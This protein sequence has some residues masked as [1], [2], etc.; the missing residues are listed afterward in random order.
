MLIRDYSKS[1]IA[2]VCDLMKNSLDYDVAPD[3]LSS[4]IGQMQS[5][6]EYKILIAEDN[7]SVLGFIGL[8]LG[9]AFEI[10]GKVMRVIALAVR[11]DCQGKGIGTMLVAESEKYAKENG[12]TVIGVNSGLKRELAHKFYEKQGFSRKGYSF[13]KQVYWIAD[14]E[15]IE[16]EERKCIIVSEV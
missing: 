5:H 13:T 2:D 16:R 7:G 6:G 3:A 14:S 1:D 12:V 4:R 8:H 11:R 10:S 15:K 9:H